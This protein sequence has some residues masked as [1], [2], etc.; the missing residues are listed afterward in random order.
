MYGLCLALPHLKIGIVFTSDTPAVDSVTV[1]P[2]SSTIS[3]GQQVQ[4]KAAVETTGFANKS[5]IWSVTKGSDGGATVNSNGL[6]TIPKGFTAG[7][8]A[9][10]ITATSV[11]DN[12]KKGTANITV[13]E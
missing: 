6:V 9:I 4:L 7:A 1:S 12:T 5:V 11:F 13:T 3:A 2:A 10:Q 8:D